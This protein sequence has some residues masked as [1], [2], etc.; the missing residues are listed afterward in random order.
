M[1][2]QSALW[3]QVAQGAPIPRLYGVLDLM[4]IEG[5][6]LDLFDV[7]QAWR[8][9][10]VHL[11]QYRDKLS[12][13]MVMIAHAVRLE[14]IF[15]GSNTLLV[16]N[17]SAAMARDAGLSAAHLGQTDGTVE[18][19]RRAV[20]YLGVSTN[21][22]RQIRAANSTA[23]TY[24]AIGPVFETKTKIDAKSAVGLA[25]VRSARSLTRK[26]LVAI[27]GI[28]LENAASVLEAGAD[29]VAVISALLEGTNLIAQARAFLRAVE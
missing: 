26:P 10:G 22:E 8:D 14:E 24:I 20:P 23:C 21:T 15:R 13:S 11:V 2:E 18:A 6:G 4:A 12:P 25:G 16:L 9:A 19:A 29:S 5:R 7:A 27:G 3:E 1:D 28:K 17:D